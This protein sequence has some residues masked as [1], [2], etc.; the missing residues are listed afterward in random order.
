MDV[1][2]RLR[3]LRQARGL[4]QR[5]L[6]A[7]KYTH[8]YVST[9][10]SG[11]RNPSRA[12][13]EHFASKLGV[14][15]EELATGRTPALEAR[16]R[17]E[18]HEARVAISAGD[19]D[20]A[21]E[22]LRRLA[23]DAR[24]AGSRRLEA[25]TEQLRG[26]WLLR[27]GR[28]EEAIERYQRAEDLLREEPPAARA[29]AVDGKAAA[30]TALGDV[31][32]AVFLLESLL[33]E[34][35]R[36][37]IADPDALA[38]VHAGLVYSYLDAGLFRRAADS[39][40]ELERLVPRV[41]DP[42]RLGQMH[43]NVARQYLNEGRV[44]DAT[45]SLQRAEDAYRQEGLLAE[46]GGASLARGYVL[47]RDGDLDGAERELER[48]REIFERTDDTAD[49]TRT[50]NELG[51][52]ERL[53]GRLE[54][55]VRHL[56]RSIALLGT[57]DAP[58]LGRAHYE[59]GVA[60][61]DLDDT[62]AEKELRAAAEIYERTGQPVPRAVAAGAL[63]SVFERRGETDAALEAYRDGIAAVEPLL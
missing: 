4:T 49:L 1:G 36:A 29:E 37:G 22:R 59:L 34:I 60:L 19:L 52:V 23:R 6:G 47:L 26:L 8:A 27:T 43:M 45:A 24:R 2:T 55:A 58:V 18:M 32:Y 3:R 63:A 21:E 31:R 20:G 16:L 12:A 5:E 48:A 9:I 42:V 53:R 51:R 38:R 41:E 56:E 13:L 7:P 14:E 46:T 40:A 33:D 10:E 61:V 54:D 57:T 11:R 17:L 44:A 30:F 39:A 35:D 28:P 15:V 25:A 50:L 62:R